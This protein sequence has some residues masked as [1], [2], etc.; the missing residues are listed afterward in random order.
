MSIERIRSVVV[1]VLEQHEMLRTAIYFDENRKMLVQAVQSVDNNDAYSFE[2][3][4]NDIQSSNGIVD[5]LRK[6]SV[7]H[8]AELEQGLVVRCH[9]VK[10][11][12][13]DDMDKLYPQDFG[14]IWDIF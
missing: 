2:I 13:D 10:V 5:L 3:T 1:A 14:I 7:K 12:Y 4:A 11:G 9:L 6:E 8:F